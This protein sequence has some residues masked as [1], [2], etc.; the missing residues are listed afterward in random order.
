MFTMRNQPQEEQPKA[1]A[2]CDTTDELQLSNSPQT[3]FSRATRTLRSWEELGRWA[4][5][6]TA[7]SCK[8][9]LKRL[10]KNIYSHRNSKALSD[11]LNVTRI[12]LSSFNRQSISHILILLKL[13]SQHHI[14]WINTWFRVPEV[15]KCSLTT[16]GFRLQTLKKTL[17][18]SNDLLLCS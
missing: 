4:G 17:P 1:P 3:F 11:K 12:F 15:N 7:F 9:Y 14:L 18:I 6:M 13:L 8:G 16:V 2:G 10:L 5:K